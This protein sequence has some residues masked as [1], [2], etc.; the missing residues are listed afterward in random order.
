M[1]ASIVGPDTLV[2][3]P[4]AVI[5]LFGGSRPPQLARSLGSASHEF[6]R[7]QA[8]GQAAPAGR[9]GRRVAG[10][11]GGPATGGRRAGRALTARAQRAESGRPGEVRRRRCW[12]RGPGAG[13]LQCRHGRPVPRGRER[14]PTPSPSRTSA[15]RRRC[16]RCSPA[17]GSPST[18]RDSVTHTL[19]STDHRFGTGDMPAGATATL[20][21]PTK[22]GVYAYQ[23]T[24][25]MFMTGTLVVA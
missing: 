9:T 11:A 4:V 8:E 21:A 19:T 16:W 14:A 24:I 22:A 23:C 3:L 25:H 18:N 17:P 13:R 7:G 20:V 1:I 2:I 6:R 5:A 12:W 15:T 10:W